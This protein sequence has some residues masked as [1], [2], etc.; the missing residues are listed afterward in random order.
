MLPVAAGREV[1][2]TRAAA[3]AA[4]AAG[5]RLKHQVVCVYGPAAHIDHKLACWQRQHA[6]GSCLAWMVR[7]APLHSVA[8]CCPVM[9]ALCDCGCDVWRGNRRWMCTSAPQLALCY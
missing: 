2:C 5:G 8:C 3:A 1:A 6:C 7:Y 4:E 9:H